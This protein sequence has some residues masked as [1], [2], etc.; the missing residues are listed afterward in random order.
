[1]L[2]IFN[3]APLKISWENYILSL[4]IFSFIYFNSHPIKVGRYIR[5]YHFTICSKIS[6]TTLSHLLSNIMA[7]HKSEIKIIFALNSLP[8][9]KILEFLIVKSLFE[10]IIS[11]FIY[12]FIRFI[13]RCFNNSKLTFFDT[14]TKYDLYS[15]YL[16]ESI[17]SSKYNLAIFLFLKKLKTNLK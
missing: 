9:F 11:M 8:N 10:A 1:M 17:L 6:C 13:L 4:K 2:L 12:L 15:S 16:S 3:S 5:A 7:W 14:G